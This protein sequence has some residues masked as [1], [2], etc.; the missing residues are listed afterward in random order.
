MS[1]SYREVT[2]S[3]PFI[4]KT[5]RGRIESYWDVKP[6]GDYSRDSDT[7]SR[8]AL[9]FMEAAHQTFAGGS[10]IVPIIRDM[11]EGREHPHPSA[12]HDRLQWHRGGLPLYAWARFARRVDFHR[13]RSRPQ[14]A[15][16]ARTIRRKVEGQ[17]RGRAFA[18][19]SEGGTCGRSEATEVS[20]TR[21]LSLPRR[22]VGAGGS[23]VPRPFNCSVYNFFTFVN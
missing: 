18:A 13:H 20:P 2:E 21:G 16:R 17:V 1:I 3:F 15:G 7:G 19:R 11:M 23:L 10:T 5:K 8:F 6:T 9:A 14:M 4:R 12:R 22:A